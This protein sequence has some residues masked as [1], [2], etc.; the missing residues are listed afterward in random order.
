MIAL[1][2]YINLQFRK[3]STVNIS[4]LYNVHTSNS[5]SI[6]NL[7]KHHKEVVSLE[8]STIQHFYHQENVNV[9]RGLKTHTELE[10]VFGLHKLVEQHIFPSQETIFLRKHPC[11]LSGHTLFL[12]ID[13]VQMCVCVL[14][15]VCPLSH[16]SVAQ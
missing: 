9:T 1:L 10:V 15:C 16:L 12:E 7:S 4:W 5:N 6:W 13:P 3:Q 8:G 11:C 2:E 14:V